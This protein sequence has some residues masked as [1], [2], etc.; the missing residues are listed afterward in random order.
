MITTPSEETLSDRAGVADFES[1]RLGEQ[2]ARS[3]MALLGTPG[4]CQTI[5]A[6][7]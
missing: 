4:P 5:G 2:S 1:R 3:V 7:V 6:G